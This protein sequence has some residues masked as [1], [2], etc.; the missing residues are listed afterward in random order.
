MKINLK[1]EGYEQERIL[2][3]LTEHA[4]E[5]L[6]EKIGSGTPFEKDGKTL[7]N[8]KTLDG[9]MR[10]AA[11]EARKLSENGKFVCVEDETVF[12]WAMHYFEEDSVEGTL[13]NADGSEYKPV[14]KAVTAQKPPI[15]HI[16]S[17]NDNLQFSFF[18][19]PQ[20]N[21]LEEKEAEEELESAAEEETPPPEKPKGNPVYQS[22]MNI[23][24]RYPESIVAYRLGDFY[25]IFGQNAVNVAK[26]LDLTLTGRDCGLETRVPMVGFPCHVADNYVSKLVSK[27]HT[28]AIAE[29]SE[30]VILRQNDLSVN[31]DTGEILGA[32]EE[33]KDLMK[34]YHKDALLALL[35]LF[36]DDATIG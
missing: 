10:Y 22:Y 9:F 32:E 1:A 11:D 31:S 24:S 13:Y 5:E 16:N 27:G 33:E 23:Q 35:D 3:Y 15:S 34:N 29:N 4:S 6:A 17:Q 19:A 2:A 12:G 26:E 20:E 8:K 36:G 21:V 30:N 7:K 28:V 25:E 14:I 18:D